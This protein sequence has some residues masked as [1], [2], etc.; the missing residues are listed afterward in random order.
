[1]KILLVILS[2]VAVLYAEFNP[3]TTI[4]MG[5]YGDVVALEVRFGLLYDTPYIEP[6]VE[7]LGVLSAKE[8]A[9]AGMN[10]VGVNVKVPVWSNTIAYGGAFG[11]PKRYNKQYFYNEDAQEFGYRYGLKYHFKSINMYVERFNGD[12]TVVGFEWR[13]K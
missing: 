10:I 7:H 2:T 6:Y 11:L 4:Q 9:A 5:K 13:F 1:M 12:E 8:K 3:Y